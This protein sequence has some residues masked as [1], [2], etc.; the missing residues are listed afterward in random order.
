M[1]FLLFFG[2]AYVNVITIFQQKTYK[3]L[4]F[5]ITTIIM[6]SFVLRISK[7]EVVN[8]F[9][10]FP[11]GNLHRNFRPRVNGRYYHKFKPFNPYLVEGK[12]LAPLSMS[13]I[14][15]LFNQKIKLLNHK[16]EGMY[17]WLDEEDAEQ[18]INASK[19]ANSLEPKYLGDFKKVVINYAPENLLIRNNNENPQFEFLFSRGYQIIKANEKF[20]LFIKNK[21]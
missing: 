11:K 8:M 14:A 18:R 3:R 9:S 20:S 6:L 17:L 13:N 1:P 16:V 12:F 2:L 5:V 21:N 15:S 10:V 7:L 19:Y 4:L